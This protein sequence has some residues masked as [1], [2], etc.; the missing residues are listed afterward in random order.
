[1]SNEI[2]RRPDEVR[3]ISDFLTHA[4]AGPS[5]LLLEGEAGIGKTTLWR[6]AQD[7]ARQHGFR[8]LAARAAASESVLAYA[9]VA[10]M[11]ATADSAALA[12]LSDPQRSAVDRVLL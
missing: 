5:A 2:P 6:W 1:M 10:D 11:I 12:A 4:A 8:V 9:A 7:Q 3:S